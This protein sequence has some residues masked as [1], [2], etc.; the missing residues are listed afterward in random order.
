MQLPQMPLKARPCAW[1]QHNSRLFS[2]RCS[3]SQGS[4]ARVTELDELLL[5]PGAAPQTFVG[6]VRVTDVEG[7]G[8]GVVAIR[9]VPAGELLLACVPL[10]VL[11]APPGRYVHTS[12]YCGLCQQLHEVALMSFDKTQAQLR[13]L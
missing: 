10:A 12:H 2:A 1:R 13:L 3:P 7:C 8:R 11:T 4:A 6:P 9:S 5:K